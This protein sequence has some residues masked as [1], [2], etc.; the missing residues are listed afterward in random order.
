[1]RSLLYVRDPLLSCF[2][3]RIDGYRKDVSRVPEVEQIYDGAG[4]PPE[5]QSIIR[6]RFRPFLVTEEECSD[7]NELFCSESD[8]CTWYYIFI[9]NSITVRHTK[10]GH[11][12][13]RRKLARCILFYLS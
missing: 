6:K 10:P 2:F 5:T 13:P 1:M 7:H 8:E 3:P 12:L 4:N 9:I 11:D